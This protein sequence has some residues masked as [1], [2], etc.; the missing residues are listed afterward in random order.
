MIPG[1]GTQSPT[2]D[3]SQSDDVS[4]N[5]SVLDTI[6]GLQSQTIQGKNLSPADR[7]ACV[8]Y[9][10]TEG[11]SIPEMAKII[12][13]HERTILRD[14]KLIQEAYALKPDPVWMQQ[15]IGRLYFEADVCTARIRRAARDKEVDPS[16]KIDAEHRC[17]QIREALVARLQQLGYLPTATQRIEAS[18]KHQIDDLPSMGDLVVEMSRLRVVAEQSNN[19]DMIQKLGELERITAHATLA[20]GITQLAGDTSTKE[21]DHA[22]PA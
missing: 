6:K 2:H 4:G 18:L 17:F 14:R 1:T 8:E 13:V 22:S 12:G 11:Y 3:S 15:V 21:A 5:R 10:M 7:Q 20:S 16:V 19:G 9:L